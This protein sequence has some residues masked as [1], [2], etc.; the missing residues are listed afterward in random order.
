MTGITAGVDPSDAVNVGQMQSYVAQEIG[1]IPS[2]PTGP[3][4]ATGY[5]G[6]SGAASTVTGPT[7]YTGYTGPSGA[8][9]YIWNINSRWIII[10]DGI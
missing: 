7:G 6:P 4:G 9:G 5:T 2:G 3:A 10:H 8:E 1:A